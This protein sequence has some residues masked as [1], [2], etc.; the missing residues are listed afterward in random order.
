MEEGILVVPEDEHKV[1]Y[2]ALTASEN[3]QLR[4]IQKIHWDRSAE[5]LETLADWARARAIVRRSE[6]G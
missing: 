2:P 5:F 3:L 6:D 4:K 1:E